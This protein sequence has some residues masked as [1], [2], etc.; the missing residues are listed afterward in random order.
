MCERS[1]MTPKIVAI[2]DNVVDC[3]PAHRLMFAG[4][5]TLNVSV[6]AARS[7]ATAGYVGAV[8]DDIAGRHIRFR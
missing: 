2:G 5:N 3:Y 8:A 1:H 6:F 7:G 4:G